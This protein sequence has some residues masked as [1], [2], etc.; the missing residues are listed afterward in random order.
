MELS[1]YIQEYNIYPKNLCLPDELF[2]TLGYVGIFKDRNE[3]H[4]QRTITIRM[5]SISTSTA[6]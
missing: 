2:H 6:D 5:K 4:H 3:N 1:V